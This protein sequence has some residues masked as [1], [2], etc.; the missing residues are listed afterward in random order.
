MKQSEAINRSVL[1]F[2]KV[3]KKIG[4]ILIVLSIIAAAGVKTVYPDVEQSQKDLFKIIIYNFLI[5]GLF[6]T[7]WSRDKFEDEMTLQVRMKAISFTFM[8]SV[9]YTIINP[10]VDIIMKQEA[11]ELGSRELIIFMLMLYIVFYTLQ[12]RSIK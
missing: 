5:L 6:F 7:A 10:L 2:P 11:T 4:I 1:H 8:T 9:F 3:F 12:K